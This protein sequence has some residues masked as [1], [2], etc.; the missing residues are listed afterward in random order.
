MSIIGEGSTKKYGSIE[1]I[2]HMDLGLYG[3]HVV[4]FNL[5]SLLELAILYVLQFH[6]L[7]LDALVQHLC[8]GLEGIDLLIGSGS[9]LLDFLTDGHHLI[10][11]GLT[12]LSLFL[13]E[14]LDFDFLLLNETDGR[15]ELAIFSILLFP[16]HIL[17]KGKVLNTLLVMVDIF[18]RFAFGAVGSRAFV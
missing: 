9:C 5:L 12:L 2:E 18:C 10:L 16:N 4:F 1:L 6:L 3:I 14:A 17:D 7:A 11:L 8:L 15:R 13:K